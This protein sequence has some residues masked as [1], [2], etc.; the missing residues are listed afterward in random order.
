MHQG[1]SEPESASST[2]DILPRTASYRFVRDDPLRAIP[3]EPPPREQT[4]FLVTVVMSE[5]Q[6]LAQYGHARPPKV[7]G[8]MTSKR[9]AHMQAG[10]RAERTMKR[11]PAPIE[12]LPEQSSVTIAQR[13]VVAL[14]VVVVFVL[15]LSTAHSRWTS[16]ESYG[17]G[18]AKTLQ[19]K[20]GITF[21]VSRLLLLLMSSGGHTANEVVSIFMN[22]TH[23]KNRELNRGTYVVVVNSASLRA[24]W[25]LHLRNLFSPQVYAVL[26]SSSNIIV[27]SP[28]TCSIRVEFG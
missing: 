11:C 10:S 19:D 5:R 2:K 12:P 25:T 28:R 14:S 16:N 8:S 15:S 1:L 18:M 9:M 3:Q 23:L 27:F 26:G 6:K 4:G 13:G 20:S 17:R 7:Y 24:A 21:E 22:E